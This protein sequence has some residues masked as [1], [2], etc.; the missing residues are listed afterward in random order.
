MLLVETEYS[1][2][3]YQCLE[4]P[5]HKGACSGNWLYQIRCLESCQS[6][7]SL[8]HLRWCPTTLR[9]VGKKVITLPHFSTP[10]F[11]YPSKTTLPRFFYPSF[12]YLKTITL[13][14]IILLIIIL[15]QPYHATPL[16]Y[17]KKQL[18]RSSPFYHLNNTSAINT[19]MI[20]LSMVT[21]WRFF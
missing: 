14:Q 21:A 15:P 6:L 7:C 2:R 1:A 3:A 4:T 5:W 10:L 16:S 18:A 8:P 11:F 17:L 13:Q 9:F 19:N 20:D 12:S